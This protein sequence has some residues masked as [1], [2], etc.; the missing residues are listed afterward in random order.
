[1]S[2]DREL[3]F[4]TLFALSD[5]I[6]WPESYDDPGGD[7]RRFKVR[8]RKLRLFSD[9]DVR[10]EQPYLGQT[11]HDEIVT[12]VTG[13]PYRWILPATWVIYHADGLIP[14]FA[15]SITNNLILQA[16]EK[17][18]EPKPSDQGF[19]EER[20]TLSGLVYHCYIDGT[21]FKDPGDI[22][23]Q[24]MMMVPIKMLVP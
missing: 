15:P 3:L 13:M 18:L 14:G 11:E 4:R 24:A 17:S 9:V 12:Q 7:Q 8:E 16:V 10:S 2:L 19:F 5:D 22:D 23:N 6:E 1:M 21:I 20:N